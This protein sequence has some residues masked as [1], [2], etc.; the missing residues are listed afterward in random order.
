MEQWREDF[1]SFLFLAPAGGK[2]PFSQN[3]C[4]VIR[5]IPC[6]KLWLGGWH[7]PR[8]NT[9]HW[10]KRKMFCY[11]GIIHDC[12]VVMPVSYSYLQLFQICFTSTVPKLNIS[13]AQTSITSRVWMFNKP[14]FLHVTASCGWRRQGVPPKTNTCHS[15]CLI[16]RKCNSYHYFK[17]PRNVRLIVRITFTVHQN[18][19]VLSTHFRSERRV[20]LITYFFRLFPISCTALYRADL[21]LS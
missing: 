5:E 4:F 12:S 15:C 11:V 20:W 7:S 8:A 1:H 16:R 21:L 17:K 10:G 18:F 13:T 6:L 2:W 9:D 3:V 19:Q 14:V